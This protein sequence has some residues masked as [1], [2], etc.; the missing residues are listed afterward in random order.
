MADLAGLTALVTGSVHGLA[1][2]VAER[3][4]ADGAKV[5]VNYRESG[6][7]AKAMVRTLRAEGRAAVAVQADMGDPAQAEALVAET[8]R[9]FGRLDLLVLGAGPFLPQRVPVAE[10][11]AQA[12]AWRAMADANVAGSV[13]AIARALPGM[14]RR[15]FGR[16]V[17][18]GF[19]SVSDFPAWPGRAAYAAAKSALWS[20]TRTLALE[21][22]WH[23]ITAN[24]V[25]PGNIR[26]PF[27]EA[28][29]AEARARAKE[30]HRAP[31]G[32]PGSGE[33]VAR[34]VRFLVDRDADFV[35]GSVI[36][37]TGGESVVRD[38]RLP[39]PSGE[40]DAGMR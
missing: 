39:H 34:V 26:A 35:T 14:R 2:A 4:A 25:A 11:D 17:T 30:G 15:R 7:D 3:L 16:I 12:R 21:E 24:M 13:A 33:D 22:C 37:V 40:G 20:Y 6:D 32:R 36:Y 1:R 18:F 23:G 28:T 9:V 38:G 27:K 10:Q 31:I 19:D 29:I 8:E 5:V